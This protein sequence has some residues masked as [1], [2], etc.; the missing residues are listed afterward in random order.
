MR[1]GRVQAGDLLAAA[2][3]VALFL[4]MELEWFR[5]HT[6]PGQSS[7]PQFALNAWQTFDVGDVIL[8]IVSAIAVAMLVVAVL[9]PTLAVA[10]SVATTLA[11]VVGVGAV[12]VRLVAQPGANEMVDIAPGAWLG[13]LCA[14]GVF[15]GGY[16]GMRAE[17]RPDRRDADA[18]AS[19]VTA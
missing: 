3:G 8:A 1:I 10:M 12:F 18:P 9:S 19:S 11:G 4:S 5:E 13:L 16:L 6:F 2:A 17:R 15:L 14:I 7:E